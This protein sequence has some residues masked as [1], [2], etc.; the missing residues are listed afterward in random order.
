MDTNNACKLTC[1]D[2]HCETCSA[3]NMC[4]TCASG[5][6]V[7]KRTTPITFVAD[8]NGNPTTTENVR[9]S[10]YACKLVGTTCAAVAG[11]SART[12]NAGGAAGIQ[13]VTCNTDFYESGSAGNNLGCTTC[14]NQA[15][16]DA[17]TPNTCSTT[18]G[19][20]TKTP[21]TSVT[22]PGYS[23][24]G[25]K[26]VAAA[27]CND[28]NCDVCSAADTCTT[29]D[30]AYHGADILFSLKDCGLLL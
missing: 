27:T 28:A 4:N 9:S 16:C 24:D 21:C 7:W 10:Y 5:Y 17:S 25:D 23:L 1:N 30:S 29:C 2:A 26:V 14:T 6:Q 22:A 8:S 12:C 19:I 13:T 3:A 15:N 20:T 11:S 18:E